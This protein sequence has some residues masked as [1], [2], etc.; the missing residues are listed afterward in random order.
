MD[1]RE[2]AFRE[3]DTN[4]DKQQ[5]RKQ[6]KEKEEE[7]AATQTELDDLLMVFGDLEEKVEKYKVSCTAF[8]IESERFSRYS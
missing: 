1:Y 3:W 2:A 7:K 5:V 8:Q 4:R 6:M